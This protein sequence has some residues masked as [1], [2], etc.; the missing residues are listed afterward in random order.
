MFTPIPSRMDE[1]VRRYVG[2]LDQ[3]DLLDRETAALRTLVL[4][5]LK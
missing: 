4:E 1:F 3:A 2:H 5:D